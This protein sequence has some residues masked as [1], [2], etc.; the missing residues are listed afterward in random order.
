MDKRGGVAERQS[1]S[2][3]MAARILA[4]SPDRIRY[5]VKRKLVKPTASRGR[6]YQ[7]S[8]EDL[9][10]MRLTKELLPTRRRLLPLKRCLERLSGTL[11]A[12]RPITAVKLY[13][14]DGR[15]M[16]RDGRARFEAE[17]GQLL[18]SFG[19]REFG[20]AVHQADSPARM[21]R[22]LSAAA[23]LEETNPLRALRLYHEY[24]E[25]EPDDG[26]IHRRL[27]RLFELGGDLQSAIRHLDAAAV[28]EPD[29]VEIHFDL[30]V[31]YRKLQDFD[32]A[33]ACFKQ[34][35]ER[36]PELIEAHLH[37]AQIYE[38][39]GRER[40]SFRHLSAAYRLMNKG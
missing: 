9:L 28:L 10:M 19:E 23:E 34:A 14:E 26:A 15:I 33:T 35:L 16:V 40:D 7:F 17:T 25:H 24:L 27:S 20:E 2:T 11:I 29:L 4:I 3:R 1:F 8:F 39:Q 12:D 6:H 37:L 30:G 22:L 5:W 13:H 18:L 21:R 32:R 31:L 38:Q 36:D